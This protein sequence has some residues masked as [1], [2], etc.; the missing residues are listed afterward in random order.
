MRTLKYFVKDECQ[1]VSSQFSTKMYEKE[2]IQ[3]ENV[4]R[5]I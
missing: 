2:H 1:A 3:Y 5:K 4:L